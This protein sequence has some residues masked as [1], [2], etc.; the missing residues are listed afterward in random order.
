MDINSQPNYFNEILNKGSCF[1]PL[2]RISLAEVGN[3]AYALK[4]LMTKQNKL[5]DKAKNEKKNLIHS[6]QTV[7]KNNILNKQEQKVNP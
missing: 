4:S 6:L 7:I 5:E 1:E 3:K 2:I